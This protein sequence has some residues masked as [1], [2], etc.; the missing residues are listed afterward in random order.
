MKSAI[1]RILIAG[2]I[3]VIG[4]VVV[5]DIASIRQAQRL[6]DTSASVRH[7]NQ[8]LY[9]TQQVLVFS[10]NYETKSKEFLLTG[11]STLHERLWRLA[12]QLHMSIDSLRM[13]TVDNPI[14][15]LR[16]DSLLQSTNRSMALLNQ[17]IRIRQLRG[18]EPAAAIAA[19][20]TELPV[21]SDRIR[22]IVQEM[23]SEENR[24][25]GLRREANRRTA[26]GLQEV[27]T[28]LI[29]AIAVLLLILLLKIRA[30]LSRAKKAKDQLSRFNRE[31]EEQVMLKTADLRASQEKY[32]TIF[33][34]SP[35]PKWIY[36]SD[37]LQ[38]IEVNEA[39]VANYGYSQAEFL[40]MKIGDIRPKEDVK[41]LM[42]ELGE[43]RRDNPEESR[44]GY[45]RHLKKNGEIIFV[46]VTAH[47]LE[48]ERRNARMVVVNDITERRKAELLMQQLNEDLE[49]RAAELA[50]SNAELER[51][52]YVASHDLQE[53]LR[54][55]S[56]FL[57]LLQKKYRGQLDEK[58]DQYI[59]YAVDGAERMK[60]LIMDLLEY[61]R[62]GSGKGNFVPVNMN[63]VVGEVTAMYR[64]KIMAAGGLV[65]VTGHLPVINA[66][67]VQMVQLF[68]NLIGNS[69]KYRSE[70][71]PVIRITAKEQ[72]DSWQFSVCDNGIGI[73][74]AFW[75]KIFIIF[76][77]LHNKSEYSGTGIGLA[78]CKKIVERHGGHIRVESEPKM[79]STF[80]F[81]ISKHV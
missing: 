25:L 28:A 48:Y 13:L 21:V 29:V 9:Q 74:P 71:P 73:D 78:I 14:Q 33:Y 7:T 24:L 30:D 40:E 59:H 35:L 42:E 62:V 60:T 36:D 77:R 64:D 58:A 2:I 1:E 23:Q 52:A 17:Q 15:Q 11:E 44:H 3:L 66:E 53:P 81:T 34:K 16:I 68:Q 4:G 55:V 65:A 5:F 39:A 54:M 41:L 47:P 37:T 56:S 79:G 31:L 50:N 45:W 19:T 10:S 8:V 57:Q 27:L 67:R 80:F 26:S 61:S 12:V 32:K 63:E 49:K 46:E 20:D 75:D 22:F 72:P 18:L 70:H 43:L 51:F 38:F 69:L 6:Q 76:Q